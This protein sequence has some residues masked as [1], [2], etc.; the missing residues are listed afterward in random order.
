MSVVES[1]DKS[2][3]AVA[4]NRRPK[5]WHHLSLHSPG[6]LE[7]TGDFLKYNPL[8]RKSSVTEICL[9]REMKLST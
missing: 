4:N 3:V 1:I 8:T 9:T 7:T 5:E 6:Q 2:M